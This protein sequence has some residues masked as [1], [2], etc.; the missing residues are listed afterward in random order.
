MSRAL[1]SAACALAVCLAAP[2]AHAAV[3]YTAYGTPG[4]GNGQFN[5]PRGIAVDTQ[6]FVYVTDTGNRR[7]QIFREVG[8]PFL[9]FQ[10]AWGTQGN[11]AGQFQAPTGI[12]V[13]PGQSV[14]VSDR[15]NDRVGRFSFF[16]TPEVDFGAFRDPS[17]V[18]VDVTGQVFVTD[19][20][21]DILAKFTQDGTLV[22]TFG[23]PGGGPGNAPGQFN[24]PLDVDINPRGTELIVADTLNQRIQRFDPDGVPLGQIPATGSPSGVAI[25]PTGNTILFTQPGANDVQNRLQNGAP[26]TPPSFGPAVAPVGTLNA[27]YG[28]AVDCVGNIFI[29][30]TANN[31]IVRYGDDMQVPPCQAPTQVSQTTLSGQQPPRV[32]QTLTLNPGQ[33]LGPPTPTVNYRWQRCRTDVSRTCGDIV[34]ARSL[35][36][37]VQAA[38]AGFRLRAVVVAVNDLGATVDSP[39]ITDPVPTAAAAPPAA[40]GSSNPSGPTRKAQSFPTAGLALVSRP[41]AGRIRVSCPQTGPNRCEVSAKV[42]ATRVKL[43]R[44][45]TGFNR[46]LSLAAGGGTMKAGTTQVFPIRLTRNGKR[47]VNGGGSARARLSVQVNGRGRLTSNLSFTRSTAARFR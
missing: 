36:Y 31:R 42:V 4:T 39:P 19:A 47:L 32:G 10:T 28:V 34:G 30:D 25:D 46:R 13:G 15:G 27:P 2:V 33:F 35:S 29:A 14:F 1:V 41:S 12:G 3:G 11:G 45:R 23:F 40:P 17:G 18:E 8:G 20:V 21:D 7:V 6:G 44:R 16:G 38:D 9:N 22:N 26:G 5:A 37:T 24:Q 43:R